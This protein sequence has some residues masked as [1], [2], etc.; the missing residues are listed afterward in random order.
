MTT[1][2]KRAAGSGTDGDFTINA[3]TG[4]FALTSA[5]ATATSTGT[6]RFTNSGGTG[7]IVSQSTT[8]NRVFS[9]TT[10]ATSDDPVVNYYQN[11]TTTTNATPATIHTVTTADVTTT[12]ITGTITA[13]RTGGVS[14]TAEDGAAY[15]FKAVYKNTT[16]AVLI[17]SATITVIGESQAGWDVT[18]NISGDDVQIQVTG[19]ANNN[20]TWHLSE[21]KIMTVSS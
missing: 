20:I 9:V 18:L 6:F 17:G 12:Y 19:A 4:N 10:T 5:S 1:G 2:Q 14:G 21:L 8:G 13:R 11:R 16:N 7:T 3:N 15:E